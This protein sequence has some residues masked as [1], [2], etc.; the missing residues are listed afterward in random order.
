MFRDVKQFQDSRTFAVAV[1]A[2]MICVSIGSIVAACVAMD[3]MSAADFE[4]SYITQNWQTKPV[5]EGLFVPHGENCPYG[6]EEA[7]APMTWPGADGYGCACYSGAMDFFNT[8]V[9]SSYHKCSWGQRYAG[10]VEDEGLGPIYM[11]TW[12]GGLM[13]VKREGQAVWDGHFNYNERPNPVDGTCP[14][15][16]QKCGAADGTYDANYAICQPDNLPCPVTFLFLITCSVR[17]QRR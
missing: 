12:R 9:Y 7:A 14:E 8:K 16:Y 11:R 4:T 15:N 1:Q 2:A 17:H 13:C 6:Y 3:F 5:S 10:C